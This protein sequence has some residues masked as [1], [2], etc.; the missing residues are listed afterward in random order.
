M[1]YAT[2]T[3][4]FVLLPG[5]PAT[6]VASSGHTETADIIDQHV[7]RADNIING[8]IAARYDVSSF[9]ASVPPMLKTIAEDITCFFTY[10]SLLSGDNANHSEWTDKF[11]D[12]MDLLDQIRDG[13][14]ELVNSSLAV[15]DE[16]TTSHDDMVT[17]THED[18]TSVFDLDGPLDWKVDP[19]LIDDI[20]R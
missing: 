20:D 3:T 15:I 2:T 9:A 11:T 16:R 10:R 5:L 13:N 6:S 18:Y 8:K 19:D 7:A 1:S 4:I 14:I 17:S 12:A